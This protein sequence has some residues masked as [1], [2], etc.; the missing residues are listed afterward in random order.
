MYINDVVRLVRSLYPSEYDAAEIYIWCNEV[1]A[2]LSIEERNVF[3]SVLLPVLN[4][5]S[6]MLPE[7]V[8]MEN[9]EYITAGNRVLEKKDFRSYGGRKFYIKGKN[10]IFAEDPHL[11]VNSVKVDYLVPYK[12]IR[13]TK[14]RGAVELDKD[15]DSFMISVCEFETGDILNIAMGVTDNQAEQI[16]ENIMLLGVEYDPDRE[17]YVCAV[18]SGAFAAADKTSDEN[19]LITRTV[20]E[21]TVCEAPYDSMYVDYVLA[22]INLYQHNTE[23]YNTYMTMF[24]SRLSAYRNRIIKRMP[25]DEC[26]LLNW[27]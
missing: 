26:R 3:K 7:G 17:V 6:V 19:T 14:Y 15:N 21:R 24:N 25:S 12:P 10:G 18:Q 2:M 22:K 8:D 27:W 20:T 23:G 13:L 1:S 4:D 9:V 11:P 16:F 5:G